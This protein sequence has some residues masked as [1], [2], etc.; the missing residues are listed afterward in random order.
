MHDVP[1]CERHTRRRNHPPF[2]GPGAIILELQGFAL[3][4][5]LY[6]QPC[7]ALEP[8]RAFPLLQAA[9][10]LKHVPCHLVPPFWALSTTGLSI[11]RESRPTPVRGMRGATGSG[12]T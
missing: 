2:V 8:R 3:D 6:R 11:G 9:L 12:L 10:L 4:R 7:G 5:E 1:L